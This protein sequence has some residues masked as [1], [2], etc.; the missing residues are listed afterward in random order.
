MDALPLGITCHPDQH[1]FYL[2]TENSTY[3]IGITQDT[4]QVLNLYWGPR[5]YSVDDI[6]AAELQQERS[7]QDPSLTTAPEEYPVFGGL[8]YGQD[9]LKVTFDSGTRELDL[10]YTEFWAYYQPRLEDHVQGQQPISTTMTTDE[11]A[12]NTLVLVLSDQYYKQLQ[13]RLAY[14]LFC[15]TDIIERSATIINKLSNPATGS[16]GD[17]NNQSLSST[18]VTIH[19]EKILSAAFHLPPTLLSEPRQLTTLNGA[20]S[21]ETQVNT[22]P[23][24]TNSNSGGSGLRY[25]IGSTHGIPS[26]Q[27]YPYFAIT[28]TGN[29]C[30]GGGGNQEDTYFGS[31]A[32][33]GNWMITVD[34]DYQGQTRISGG[35][36][37]HDFGLTLYSGETFTTPVF[38]AGYSPSGLTGARRQ[39]PRHITHR[40][41]QQLL[42]QQQQQQQQ[43][44]RFNPVLYNSWEAAGFD[45]NFQQQM[46]LANQ[47]AKMGV[48]LFVVDDGWFRGRTSDRAGLGDWFYDQDKFPQGLKPLADHVHSM[49]MKFGLWFEPEMVNPDSDLYRQHPDWVYH[50]RERPR[51]QARHQLVLDL[52]NPQVQNYVYEQLKRNINEIGIDYI[53]WDMNRPISEAGIQ[54]LD[55][56]GSGG[57]CSGRDAREVWIRHVNVFYTLL[58]DLKTDFPHLLIESCCSGGG[59][60]DPGVLRLVDQCW[61]SDNTQPDARLIIQHGISFIVPPKMMSCWVTDMP[62]DDP[63]SK[64]I[65]LGY[66][67]HVSFMGALGVGSNIMKYT[68]EQQKEA[69]YWIQVYKQLRHVLQL[70]DLDWIHADHTRLV[71]TMTTTHDRKEA[72][73]LVFRPSSPFWL[74]IPP[75]RLRHLDPQAKYSL[76]IWTSMAATD[77]RDV[78]WNTYSGANLMYKGLNLPYL[79]SGANKSLV[80]WLKRTS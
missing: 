69:R 21:A 3:V 41:H 37:P 18:S 12:H 42:Q 5:L 19:I 48:E 76:K 26:A 79:A 74:P 68:D 54:Q 46:A 28:T 63:G 73:V 56:D 34:V 15:D 22:T 49:N 13:V 38:M 53:K 2:V 52:T 36:H 16:H 47:A 39:L 59:R 11:H 58:Q 55:R 31:M 50:Y 40:R 23:L 20:W 70:G 4:G 1:R 27:A 45:V 17:N 65:P 29:A 25:M 75:I 72:V 44:P 10:A 78:E 6:P 66:R 67:F 7:S 62:A 51:S 33:S 57:R 61:T 8:R 80:I 14:Q 9:S 43:K 60:A 71:A 30:G 24:Q 32:W 64:S 77:D 35:L